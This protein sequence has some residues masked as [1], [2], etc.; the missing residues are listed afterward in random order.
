M[1][2]SYK[3]VYNKDNRKNKSGV[4]SIFIR[5]TVDGVSS[6]F[7]LG[8]RVDEKYWTGKEDRWIKESHPC[9]FELNTLIRK[10]LSFLEKHV[11]RQKVFFDNA[12]TL[13]GIKEHF[14]KKES[15]NIFNEYVDEFIKTVTGKSVNTLKKYKTFKRYLDEFNPRLKFNQLNESLFQSFAIFIEKKGMLGVTVIKYF[16]PFKVIVKQATKEGYFEK[17]P[18]GYADIGVK[19]TKGKRVYL[20]IEEI[21]LL[22]MWKIPADRPTW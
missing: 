7:N 6:Y 12:I 16:D 13:N 9:A 4:H 3:A 15:S 2:Y 14:H 5:A 8:E 22:K 10:K 19:P 21:S 18:F 11:Q 17:D 20:E 1:G